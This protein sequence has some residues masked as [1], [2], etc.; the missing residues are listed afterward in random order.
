MIEKYSCWGQPIGSSLLWQQHH[1]TI[2]RISQMIDNIELAPSK[3]DSQTT[4]FNELPAEMIREIILRLNDYQD[5]INSARASP[6]MKQMILSQNVWERLCRYHF[7]EQQL[8]TVLDGYRRTPQHRRPSSKYVRNDSLE[9]RR[10]TRTDLNKARSISNTTL[11]KDTTAITKSTPSRSIELIGSQLKSQSRKNLSTSKE[12][13]QPITGT[14]Q[15]DNDEQNRSVRMH[16]QSSYVDR[17][18]K[19]FDSKST[20]GNNCSIEA[21]QASAPVD[22]KTPRTYD[23][24]KRFKHN[25]NDKNDDLL[26]SSNSTVRPGSKSNPSKQSS[27]RQRKQISSFPNKR[28]Q[29]LDWEDVFHQLRK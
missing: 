20:A 8:K 22:T 5:L 12:A 15:S 3:L 16:C 1:E 17:T 26:G 21:D 19:L 13:G 9:L 11:D 24:T 10:Q 25:N 2:E 27:E 29:D 18:K 4:S 23:S 14:H 28:A 7:N 6:I